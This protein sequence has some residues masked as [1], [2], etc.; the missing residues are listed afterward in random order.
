MN[1]KKPL[2]IAGAVAAIGS[3]GLAG[4]SLVSADSNTAGQDGLVDK[5]AQKFNLNKSDVKAVFDQ[6]RADHQAKMQ[7]NVEKQLSQAVT[8]G[9]LTA[10][11]K[12]K[13]LAKRKE[14]QAS[15]DSDRDTMKNKTPAE[16]KA[17][18]EAKR[19]ELEQWAKDNNIP[20]EYLRFVM[21]GPGGRGHGPMHGPDMDGDDAPAASSSTNGSATAQ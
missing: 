13:I 18:M 20:T 1:V 12:D 9:K 2:L 21:G 6:D 5:I 16:R 7:A 11:Q 8:D 19:T 3:A 14:M 4:S 17:A 15:R 10:D